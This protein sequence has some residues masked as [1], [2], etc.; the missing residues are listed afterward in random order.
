MKNVE[1]D[2]NFYCRMMP[3][4]PLLT[5]DLIFLR[6]FIASLDLM[7]LNVDN[8]KFCDSKLKKLN[9]EIKIL[10]NFLSCIY[11]YDEH[12]TWWFFCSDVILIYI[13]MDGCID[14]LDIIFW[15]R[16][17]SRKFMQFY[18]WYFFCWLFL[19]Y[20]VLFFFVFALWK[21]KVEVLDTK[22][23]WTSCHAINMN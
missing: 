14:S 1:L 8:L 16:T 19:R 10:L 15:W 20:H 9:F 4:G 21:K 7:I 18:L 11:L 22:S 6:K 17:N 5:T 23:V 12:Q 3:S 2:W 13:K